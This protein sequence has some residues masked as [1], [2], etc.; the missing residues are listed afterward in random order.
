MAAAPIRRDALLPGL[1]G[2]FPNLSLIDNPQ[3]LQSAGINAVVEAKSQPNHQYLVRADAHAAYPANYVIGVVSHLARKGV[4]SLATTM[5]ATGTTCFAKGAAWIV[6]TPLGSG[7]SGH[8]GG[9][10]SGFVDHGHHAGF[11]LNWFR[12]IGGYDPELAV[13]EDAD[14]D[15]RLGKIGGRI[16]LE[17]SLRVDYR[18]R[19]GPVGLARQYWRYGLGRAKTT[20]KNRV[21]PRLR[22][23]IP[24]INVILLTLSL[25][26]GF[27]FAPLWSWLFLYLGILFVAGL[28][29]AARHRSL[30]GLL[31]TAALAIMHNA[32]GAGFLIGLLRGLLQPS[33]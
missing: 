28:W 18:M 24:A 14:Y 16:W 30:C 21:R 10:Q 2:E 1:Q 11:D 19:S 9:T 20:L 29:M 27:L 12:K 7:G 3:R 4:A 17:A 33:T 22:Q 25:T 8:R 15:Q 23:T 5:D 31:S 6:D 32:W 13:N 26:L